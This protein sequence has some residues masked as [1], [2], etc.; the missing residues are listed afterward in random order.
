[1]LRVPITLEN[2]ED[3]SEPGASAVGRP[4][5]QCAEPT[6]AAKAQVAQR[7]GGGKACDTTTS[8]STAA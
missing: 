4:A 3:P 7:R 5:C 8:R 6:W 1:M 2:P